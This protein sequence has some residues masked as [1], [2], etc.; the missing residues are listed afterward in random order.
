MSVFFNLKSRVLIFAWFGFSALL[1]GGC[2]AATWDAIGKGAKGVQIG[3]RL[4]ECLA[5]CASIDPRGETLC[6]INCHARE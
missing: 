5:H 2:S 6:A 4:G 3:D 1:I